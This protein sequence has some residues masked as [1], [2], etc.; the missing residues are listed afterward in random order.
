MKEK[1]SAQKTTRGITLIALAVTVAVLLILSGV[2]ITMLHGDN[3]ILEKAIE[4]KEETHKQEDMEK[5]EI[6]AVGYELNSNSNYANFF[7]KIDW[8]ESAVYNE[9]LQKTQIVLKDCKHEY[10]VSNDGKVTEAKGVVLSNSQVSLQLKTG[11]TV[12]EEITASLIG[13]TGEISWTISDNTIA[14]LSSSTGNNVTVTALKEGETTI[15]ATCGKYSS[16]CKIIVTEAAPEIQVTI[17]SRYSESASVIVNVGNREASEI[18]EYKYYIKLSTA[19]DSEYK[20]VAGE[21][22]SCTFTGI[23]YN[24][25]YIVK[26]EVL[27]IRG[28]KGTTTKEVDMYC[29]VAGTQVLTESGMKNIEDIKVGEKVYTINLDTNQKELK[30]VNF[31]IKSISTEIYEITIGDEVIKATPKHQFYIV[32][33]GWIRAY[34]LEKGDRVS[35]KDNSSLE[36]TNI[37]LKTYEEPIDVYNLTIDSHHN[38][39]ITQYE[40]LVHNAP[41]A[42]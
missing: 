38:Y 11:Q 31:L 24:K 14:T 29:F 15:T 19:E 18:Q 40:L 30:E 37:E 32:D 21:G 41:S 20:E 16:A 6:A 2:S 13:I 26:V 28:N 1:F 33:K 7:N 27:D 10:F 5:I 25:T 34:E 17:A 36:I 42:T 23:V 3:G 22:N 35:A 8:C 39:L 12:T 9:T 4:A